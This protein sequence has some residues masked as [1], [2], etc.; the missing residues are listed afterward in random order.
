[1]AELKSH[2]VLAKFPKSNLRW[3]KVT[4]SFT[5][6]TCDPDDETKKLF[7]KLDETNLL[8]MRE[9]KETN[10]TVEWH[11]LTELW[12]D[13]DIY[14]KYKSFFF[15]GNHSFTYQNDKFK[16]LSSL[17]RSSTIHLWI[18]YIEN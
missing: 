14:G 18:F 10:S 17:V 3:V 7:D 12:N 11:S 13:E 8:C 9:Y 16:A 4:L 2:E 1:M 5:L 15:D 6:D